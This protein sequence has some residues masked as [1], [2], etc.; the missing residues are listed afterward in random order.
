V[1]LFLKLDFVTFMLKILL[2]IHLDQIYRELES[3]EMLFN[4]LNF[5]V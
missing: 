4:G 2:K 1:K 3:L 5:K